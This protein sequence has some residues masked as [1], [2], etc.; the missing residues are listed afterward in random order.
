MATSPVFFL[1]ALELTLAIIGAIWMRLAGYAFFLSARPW[2]DT[3]YF[4]VGYTAL[5]ILERLTR[6]LAP[7]AYRELDRLMHSIGL[8]LRTAGV[9]YN[10]ALFLA[11][12]SAVGEE[13]FFRG[14]LQNALAQVAGPTAGWILQAAVFALGHPAP[15]RAGRLYLAWAFAAGLIFGALYLLSGSLVPGILAHFL[16]NAKGFEE[17]FEAPGPE[18]R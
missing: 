18:S 7:T 6:F 5:L 8:T 13:I 12:A 15:G 4:L 16:Y 14:A 2:H 1:F 3:F 11:L 9:G 17:I 10:T